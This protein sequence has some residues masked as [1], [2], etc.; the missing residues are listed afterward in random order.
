M[1]V[2]VIIPCYNA[3]RFIGE[4]VESALR[5]THPDVVVHVVDD[6]SSDGTAAIAAG[7]GARVRVLKQARRGVSAA[8]NAAI[9]AG[10]GEFIA[11]LDADDRWHPEKISRQLALL[12]DHPDCGVVHTAVAY[13]DES[14]HAIER[15]F[16][17]AP[18]VIAHGDC[19]GDLLARNT[20]TTSTV[21]VQRAILG[22]D[23]FSPD[24]QTGEDWEVWLCL[25]R[26]T[27]FGYLDER[28]T[29]YRVHG[30][31]TTRSLDLALA[32]RLAVAERM[33]ARDLAPPHRRAAHHHRQ[34]VL[35]AMGH[36]AYDR[37]DMPRAR[38]LFSAG[39]RALDVLGACRCVVASLP[40][41][42]ANPLR[43]CWRR[44]LH[45]SPTM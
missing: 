19:L 41:W 27:R 35:V 14:G 44:L 45:A 43:S 2:D 10:D 17:P 34:R 38:R 30:N 25:A 9:D 7:F 31:N 26:R 32:G 23:R 12:R 21:L 1:R 28:L 3:A 11:F 37:G 39:R 29:E 20:I 15:P 8:R 16:G 22:H 24:L 6:G 36:L 13:I 42:V 5:Q 33:L 4:A 18:A 40:S